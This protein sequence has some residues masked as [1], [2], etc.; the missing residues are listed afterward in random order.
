MIVATAGLVGYVASRATTVEPVA[1][2]GD[3]T[4]DTTSAE[5]RADAA[6]VG[7]CDANPALSGPVEPPPGAITVEPGVDAVALVAASPP[8][9]TFWFAPGTHTLDRPVQARSGDAFVGAPGAVLTGGSSNAAAFDGRADDVTLRHLA[10]RDFR[11]GRPT[12]GANSAAVNRSVGDGWRIEDSTFLRLDGAAVFLG[13]GASVTGSCFDSNGQYGV[14][15]PARR[16]DGRPEAI[17]EVT[18]S[19]NEFVGNNP[20]DLESTGACSG[21]TGAMKLWMPLGVEVVGNH[22]HDNHGVGVWVDTNGVDIVV[23]DNLIENN[24]RSA[25]VIEL[26]YNARV[27]GNTFVGNAVVAGRERGAGATFPD[28]AVYISESGGA[29]GLGGRPARID[30]VGNR[31]VDNWNGVTLWENA[32]RFCASAE[33]TSVGY[34]TLTGGDVDSCASTSPSA[35]DGWLQNCRWR[36]TG[37]NVGDNDFVLTSAFDCPVPACG[38]NS[39][40]AST[41]DPMIRTVDSSGRRRSFESGVDPALI[42][43]GIVGRADNRFE[44]NRY[45]GRWTFSARS[46]DR[47][48][49][50]REWISEGF[51]TTSEFG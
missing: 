3:G 43:D 51:D 45:R 23:E 33:N 6:G 9:A 24:D 1:P 48:I 31:F 11:S 40:I 47:V 13:S 7:I 19:G 36:T 26:S 35:V 39:V 28:A 8:S 15:I 42:R 22:I 14:S 44:D 20:D 50:P 25:V 2:A 12:D 38:R 46:P 5:P 10:I 34:C 17:S 4:V 30:V 32:N 16:R 27:A 41:L 49:S 37:V 21:C 18:I 29:D